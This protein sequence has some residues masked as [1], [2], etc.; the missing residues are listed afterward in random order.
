MRCATSEGASGSF[1]HQREAIESL[2]GIE[3]PTID[4]WV[5]EVGAGSAVGPS[6]NALLTRAE[7]GEAMEIHVAR[8]DRLARDVRT[9]VAVLAR[10]KAAGAPIVSSDLPPLMPI[11]A[12]LAS[13]QGNWAL[14]RRQAKEARHG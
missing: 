2:L 5:D 13:L 10:A 4:E 12:S 3:G 1:E 14:P 9:T 11:K 8:L 7:A 6:L